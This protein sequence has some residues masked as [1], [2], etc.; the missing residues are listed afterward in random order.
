MKCYRKH[1]HLK[2]IDMNVLCNKEQS[3]TLSRYEKGDYLPDVETLLTY[4]IVFNV[5]VSSLLPEYCTELR[6]RLT[7]KIK[8]LSHKLGSEHFTYSRSKRKAFLDSLFT[9]ISC[10]EEVHDSNIREDTSEE[11][12]I[13]D[14][15]E[16]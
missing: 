1:S 16:Q 8:A 14:I 12:R 4:A 9:R 11:D 5:P 3:V 7:K 15:S 10:L 2:Q 13:S 6:K